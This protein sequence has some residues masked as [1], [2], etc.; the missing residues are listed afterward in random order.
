MGSELDRSL[1]RR[2]AFFGQ[3]EIGQYLISIGLE[4]SSL[5]AAGINDLRLLKRLLNEDASV[6]ALKDERIQDRPIHIATRAGSYEILKY[7]VSVGEDI[8]RPNGRGQTPLFLIS[9]CMYEDR[10]LQCADYLLHNGA[11]PSIQSVYPGG[12]ALEY[13]RNRKKRALVQLIEGSQET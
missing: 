5:H 11:D 12:T 6:I 8:N 4:P 3:R 2:A 13:A 9:E 1:N 7:L 10:S